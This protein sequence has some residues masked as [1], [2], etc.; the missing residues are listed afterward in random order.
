MKKYAK[1]KE[2][3]VLQCIGSIHQTKTHLYLYHCYAWLTNNDIFFSAQSG[4]M[5]K[6]FRAFTVQT[7]ACGHDE[8]L[9]N[10]N[11]RRSSFKSVPNTTSDNETEGKLSRLTC[12][13]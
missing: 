10:L 2:S 1:K 3:N 4:A 7:R 11:P 8:E 9:M 13:H 5:I 12:N 6:I